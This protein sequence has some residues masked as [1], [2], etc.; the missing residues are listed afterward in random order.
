M[1][2]ST[3]NEP[4]GEE[5]S[6]ALIPPE[7]RNAHLQSL[8]VP[9]VFLKTLT[10]SAPPSADTMPFLRDEGD[11]YRTLSERTY[12]SLEN[13]T[14]TPIATSGDGNMFY[15]HVDDGSES[16]LILFGIETEVLQTYDS[17]DQLVLEIIDD[18]VD[19]DFPDD[20]VLEIASDLGYSKDDILEALEFETD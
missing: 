8:G 20:V 12:S 5:L 9:S 18:I 13:C 14:V 1:L 19:E 11:A 17:F 7:K 16:R 15:L 2:L 10:E 4:E 3:V 6:H